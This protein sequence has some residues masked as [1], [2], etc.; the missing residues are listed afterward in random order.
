M[1]ALLLEKYFQNIFMSLFHRSLFWASQ[2]TLLDLWFQ[3]C[4]WYNHLDVWGAK[5]LINALLQL[6]A[7]ILNL[8]ISFSFQPRKKK[9]HNHHTFAFLLPQKYKIWSQNYPIMHLEEVEKRLTLKQKRTSN[10]MGC[11]PICTLHLANWFKCHQLLLFLH[12]CQK[13]F[14]FLS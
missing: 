12:T 5:T 2:A 10:C 11:M 1:A 9:N 6:P 3:R 14:H 13:K 4:W 7:F 8:E